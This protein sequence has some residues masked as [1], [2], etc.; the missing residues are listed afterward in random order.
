MEMKHYKLLGIGHLVFGVILLFFGVLSAL[1]SNE[2]TYETI[3][4]YALNTTST[5]FG[6]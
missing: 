4:G 1:S 3:W 6:V 5:L 2:Q